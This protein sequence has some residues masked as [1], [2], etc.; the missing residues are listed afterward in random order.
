MAASMPS[1]QL[2]I[3]QDR[4]LPTL[5]KW[6]SN[7]PIMTA[8]QKKV[9]VMRIIQLAVG[10]RLMRVK[11]V[12]VLKMIVRIVNRQTTLSV[13]VMSHN[14]IARVTAVFFPGSSSI[15]ISPP[16]VVLCKLQDF[17][18]EQFVA[19]LLSNTSSYHDN[20]IFTV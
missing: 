15:I 11:R 12:R 1:A 10:I 13:D 19:M 14:M 3:C 18:C 9:I 8:M 5:R 20:I 17:I 7:P 16:K 6:N 2:N 4:V